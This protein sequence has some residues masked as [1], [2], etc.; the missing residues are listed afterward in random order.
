MKS[1]YVGN[2]FNCI[3]DRD[4]IVPLEAAKIGRHCHIIPL[5]TITRELWGACG[6][7]EKVSPGLQ[8]NCFVRFDRPIKSVGA[9]MTGIWLPVKSLM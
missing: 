2:D 9:I 4:T 3:I 5:D 1:V 6:T 7:I 8:D